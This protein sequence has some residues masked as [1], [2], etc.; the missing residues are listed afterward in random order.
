[1][2][3]RLQ[4]MGQGNYRNGF[5]VTIHEPALALP[6]G[7]RKPRTVFVNSM[8]DLFHDEVPDEF[9]CRVFGIMKEAYWHSFQILT[10]RSERLVELS[11]KLPWPPNVWMGVSV[12]NE[13][14]VSRIGHLRETGA[15]IKFISFEPLLGP[16][17]DVNLEGIDWVIA[18]GESGPGARP[19]K[20]EWV[21]GTRDQCL[22]SNTPFFFKQWGGVNRKKAGRTLENRMWSQMPST[23]PG[24]L[25]IDPEMNSPTNSGQAG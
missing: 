7:W 20:E 17:Q 23:A 10:K 22:K 5:R 15:A 19:M 9:I 12:E 16:I 1:M 3:K 4:A 8:S 24:V 6:L 2:A 25:T 21:I 18:G 11:P 13:R 14:F